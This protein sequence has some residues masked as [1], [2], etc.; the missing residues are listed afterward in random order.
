MRFATRLQQT[1]VFIHP[2]FLFLGMV[3][4][5]SSILFA[6]PVYAHHPFGGGLPANAI[7]GFLSGIGHPVIGFDHLLFVIAAGLIGSLMQRGTVV[8]VVFVLSSLVGTGLHLLSMDLPITEVVISGSVVLFGTVLALGAGSDFI[9]VT[10][11]GAIAGI[12]HGYA[13]G[14]AIVGAEMTPLFAYLIGFVSIQLAIS[15]SAW[16][17]GKLLLKRDAAQGLLKLRFIGF[18]ICGAGSAFLSGLVLG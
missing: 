17:F 1:T 8:P 10:V 3:L 18:A 9:L 11:V 15:L 14:E 5:A 12:F 6:M 13:Y 7:E 16:K 4:T 2:F